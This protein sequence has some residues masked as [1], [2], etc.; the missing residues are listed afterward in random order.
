[1]PKQNERFC[2]NQTLNK[3]HI[4][5]NHDEHDERNIR[6]RGR[7][8]LR[9]DGCSSAFFLL[10]SVFFFLDASFYQEKIENIQV[11]G[12]HYTKLNILKE[13]NEHSK[14]SRPGSRTKEVTHEVNVN[15]DN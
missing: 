13:S 5:H 11:G 4:S 9:A 10:E 1:M 2:I 8:L 12:I 3:R 7:T 15:E 14:T 6:R